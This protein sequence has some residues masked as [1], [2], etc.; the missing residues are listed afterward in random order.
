MTSKKP[1]N[2]LPITNT[3]M[4]S[5]AH[6]S[7]LER[8]QKVAS[9]LRLLSLAWLKVTHYRSSLAPFLRRPAREINR[10]KWS[11]SIPKR[12]C[13]MLTWDTKLFRGYEGIHYVLASNEQDARER[14]PNAVVR[15]HSWQGCLAATILLYLVASGQNARG[16]DPNARLW[17]PI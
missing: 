7:T 3:G 2:V 16:G 6:L 10:V 15:C 1:C 8:D 13:S 5:P 9:C 11:D 12:Q 17:G 14:E 4:K